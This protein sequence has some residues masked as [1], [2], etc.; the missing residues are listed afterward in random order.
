MLVE[1]CKYDLNATIEL[2]QKL[3]NITLTV[4]SNVSDKFFETNVIHTYKDNKE[5]LEDKILTLKN[6]DF[7]FNKKK[8]II[9]LNT[10][11]KEQ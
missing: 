11:N 6:I 5:H 7:K 1:N 9:S 10:Q 8:V 2:Q 4:F 3:K